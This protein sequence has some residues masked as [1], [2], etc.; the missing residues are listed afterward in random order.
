MAGAGITCLRRCV[1]VVSVRFLVGV[2]YISAGLTSV[3][4]VHV[5]QP[6][7]AFRAGEATLHGPTVISNVVFEQSASP[8]NKHG[9]LRHNKTT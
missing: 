9:E 4:K 6:G 8:E 1:E 5:G 3:A 7:I 2:G